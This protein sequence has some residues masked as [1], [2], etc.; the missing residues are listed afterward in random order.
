ANGTSASVGTLTT[1]ALTLT[2]ANT[3]HADAS[4][5]LTSNWDKLIVNGAVD[6]GSTSAFQLSIASGLNF[7]AETTYTLIDATTLLGT[8]A[9]YADNTAY[10]FDGYDFTVLYDTANGD[11]NLKAV[12]EPSTWAA[13]ALAL[14]A[15]AFTQRR[16][17]RTLAQS[18]A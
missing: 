6:L 14:A 3:F 8:F 7:T 12:P 17:I 2:G 13:G 9:T 5:T 10:N 16:R 15:V 11:F 18:A 4:G 1:G